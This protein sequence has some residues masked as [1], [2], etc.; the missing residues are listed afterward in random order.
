VIAQGVH[1]CIFLLRH[2]AS[3]GK[4]ICGHIGRILTNWCCLGRTWFSN[5]EL[6]NTSL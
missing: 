6:T 4:G 3:Q 1:F 2:L 5:L